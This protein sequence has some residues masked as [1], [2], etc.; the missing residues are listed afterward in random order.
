MLGC[1]VRIR[2]PLVGAASA[3][4]LRGGTKRISAIEKPRRVTVYTVGTKMAWDPLAMSPNLMTPRN[5]GRGSATSSRRFKLAARIFRKGRSTAY[6][7]TSEIG[8][9]MHIARRAT[10]PNWRSIRA[11]SAP[12][13]IA[14]WIERSGVGELVLCRSHGQRKNPADEDG[15]LSS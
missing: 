11:R 15:P 9:W 14:C 1:L 12:R 3:R 2:V 4:S 6:P 10:R 13:T 7:S 8:S 5:S